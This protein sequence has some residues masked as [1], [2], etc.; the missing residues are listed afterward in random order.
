[1]GNGISF[2]KLMP[3]I[4][5]TLEVIE[6][7]SVQGQP[8]QKVSETLISTNKPDVVVCVCKPSY[9]GIVELR[10][11]ASPRQKNN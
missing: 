5:A 8:G 9:M 1:V 6:R 2:K 11:D 10:S 3:I 7:I 4:P